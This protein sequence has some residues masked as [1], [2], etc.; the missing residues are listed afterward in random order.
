MD[1]L[2]DFAPDPGADHRPDVERRIQHRQYL[3]RRMAGIG[4]GLARD[5]PEAAG[6]PGPGRRR[7]GRGAAIGAEAI[8]KREPVPGAVLGVIEADGTVADREPAPVPA[9]EIRLERAAAGIGVE[10]AMPVPAPAGPLQIDRDR[11]D[12][13]EGAPAMGAV[14][15]QVGG[16]AGQRGR[17]QHDPPADP[18]RAGQ[19]GPF[20]QIDGQPAVLPVQRAGADPERPRAAAQRGPA[21]FGH[22]EAPAGPIGRH[23]DADMVLGVAPPRPGVPGRKH[24]AD[25]GDHRHRP[26]AVGADPVD[27]PPGIAVRRD[28]HVEARSAIRAVAAWIP[29]SAAIGTP[30]PGCTPPPAR[31]SPGTAERAIGRCKAA[32]RPRGLLP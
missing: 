25:E 6:K 4:P 27:I 5:A 26:R 15:G 28:R 18:P 19:A 8:A 3:P 13:R 20:V 30:G 12:R 16:N 11:R 14:R 7:E 29:D 32:V 1:P 31:Y 21:A 9:A 22:R 10:I 23:V 17:R 24:R 2:A